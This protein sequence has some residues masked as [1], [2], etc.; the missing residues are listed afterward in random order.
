MATLA[1]VIG[2]HRSQ[3]CYGICACGD[4]NPDYPKYGTTAEWH[5]EHVAA[6]VTAHLAEVLGAEATRE[7]AR[8]A[9]WANQFPGEESLYG[10]RSTGEMRHMHER[11]EGPADAALAAV[12]RSLGIEATP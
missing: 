1:E 12:R 4:A 8:R 7:A 2:L 5:R 10:D 3:P 9:A 11:T 6:A